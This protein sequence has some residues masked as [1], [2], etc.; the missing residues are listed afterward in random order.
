MGTTCSR[1][2]HWILIW[3]LCLFYGAQLA[4]NLEP[5]LAPGTYGRLQMTALALDLG[6]LPCSRGPLAFD[7]AQG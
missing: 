6:T 3:G 1:G 2:H 4:L 7:L 5:Q